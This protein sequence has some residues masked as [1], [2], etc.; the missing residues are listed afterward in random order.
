VRPVLGVGAGWALF[1]AW[2]L[3]LRRQPPSAFLSEAEGGEAPI[4]K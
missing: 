1:L 4:T 3:D 2:W